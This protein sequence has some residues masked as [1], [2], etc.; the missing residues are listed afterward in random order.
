MSSAGSI[1]ATS[2]PPG[3]SHGSARDRGSAGPDHAAGRDVIYV[4]ATIMMPTLKRTLAEPSGIS[5][6]GFEIVSSVL[7]G[8]AA[9]ARLVV[10]DHRSRRLLVFAPENLTNELDVMQ[11]MTR[12]AQ[13]LPRSGLERAWA[14]A[15]GYFGSMGRPW[16]VPSEFSRTGGR[17]VF[18]FA[19]MNIKR[20]FL[21]CVSRARRQHGMKVALYLHDLLPLTHPEYTEGRAAEFRNFVSGFLDSCDLLITSSRYN[22]A[23]FPEAFA[24]FTAQP[25]PPIAVVPLAH[26]FRPWQPGSARPDL[27]HLADHEFVLCVGKIED[28]KN[29]LGLVRAWQ[30]YRS[31]A[32]R[33][34]PAHLV[35]AGPLGTGSEKVAAFLE[36]TRHVDGTVHVLAKPSDA[37]LS[38][39]YEHCLF[40]AY[41]S[42]A[43]G[44]GLPIG[45]SLWWGKTC[46]ASRNTSMPEVGGD[47]VVYVDPASVD[48]MAHTLRR[49]LDEAGHL[50]R[51]N[52]QIDRARLR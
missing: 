11:E 5:R 10:A 50:D 36:Q 25:L 6:A 1:D 15:R 28:R 44:W 23:A 41:V 32:R 42:F 24:G 4:D 22:A 18:L 21:D 48:A 27:P 13:S 26:E 7:L 35:L 31:D 39:L 12:I 49:F 34:T 43:E 2:S 52:E 38:W 9:G 37:E 47:R 33:T 17:G 29:Q 51:L 45:E 8:A 3:P 46:M 30:R 20:G 14:S 16:S 40:T 19:G